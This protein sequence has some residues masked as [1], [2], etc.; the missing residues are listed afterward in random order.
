MKMYKEDDTHF[1]SFIADPQY[2]TH[3]IQCKYLSKFVVPC[4]TRVPPCESLIL[5]T[6]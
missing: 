1:Y 3:E 6:M 5:H 4:I 2:N